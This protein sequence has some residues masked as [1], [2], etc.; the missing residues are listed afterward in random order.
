MRKRR[1]GPQAPG[2]N[3]SLRGA[4]PLALPLK[5][6][7]QT[8]NNSENEPDAFFGRRVLICRSLQCHEAHPGG[9]GQQSPPPLC[10][11]QLLCHVQVVELGIEILTELDDLFSGY[12]RVGIDDAIRHI[13]H[14]LASDE[15]T[16]SFKTK[17]ERTFG[18][19]P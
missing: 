10:S 6:V 11:R 18:H 9:I 2:A 19:I 4:D 16:S 3:V 8:R 7:Q 17:R 13:S 14:G 12:L 15:F 1:R 5:V